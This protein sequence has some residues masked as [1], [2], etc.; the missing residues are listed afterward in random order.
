MIIIELLAVAM[1]HG[2]IEM[3]KTLESSGSDHE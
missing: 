2:Y 1:A 3:K